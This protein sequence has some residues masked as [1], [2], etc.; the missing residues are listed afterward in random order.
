MIHYALQCDEGHGFDGW[1]ASSS[2]YEL[3]EQRGLVA[4]PHCASV[5]VSRALMAPRLGRKGNQQ[6]A[7]MAQLAA[8]ALPEPAGHA[9]GSGGSAGGNTAAKPGTDAG[10]AGGVA[11]GG[12]LPDHLRAM[13]QRLRQEV[14]ANC[15]YVGRD[16]AA[17]A[18]RIYAGETGPRAIYGETTREE[19]ESLA[20]DGIPCTAVPWVPRADG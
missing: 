13:L 1:F 5:K 16:F 7:D 3:Q 4:C 9:T 19:A 18:R 20:E 10:A 17:E 2:A 8:P 11:A 15:D 6:V 14:E 12:P